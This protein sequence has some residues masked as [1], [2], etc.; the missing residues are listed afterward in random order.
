MSSTNFD[1]CLAT[2]KANDTLWRTGGTDA[3]GN[4]V[5]DVSRI[6]GLTYSMCVS[7]CGSAPIPFDFASFSTQFS[8]FMLPFLALTAQLPFGAPNHFDNFA[9]IMLTIG[10]PT[11]AIFSLMITIFNSRWIQWRFERI[12]YPN[13]NLAVIV[14]DNLQESLLR[15]KQRSFDGRLSLLASQIVLPQNDQ[16]WQ[17]GAATLAFTHT[18]SMSNI[19]SV[20]WAI[21]AYIFTIASMTPSTGMDGIG[22]TVACAWLWLLP[23]VVGWLQMSPNCDEVKLRAKVAALN[24]TAYICRSGDDPAALPV[25]A[26]ELTDEHAIEWFYLLS[27]LTKPIDCD[28]IDESRSPPFY[29]YARMFPWA[30][31]V[32]EIALAF[33]AASIRASKRLTINGSLWTP[34]TPGSPPI[35]PC[36]RLGKA[37][38]AAIYILPDGNPQPRDKC[39]APGVWRRVSYSGIVACTVQ[40][41]CTGS[42][43]LA[44]WMT[45]T[46]GLGC[47]SAALLQHGI[48]STI[49]FTTILAGEIIAQR[50][51]PTNPLSYS[52]SP[53][54][55]KRH[56]KLSALCRRVGKIIAWV[57]AC[58]F[59]A[60]DLISF[61]N[62][63]DNRFCA[64]AV[65]GRGAHTAFNVICMTV[66]CTQRVGGSPLLLS[67]LRPHFCFGSLSLF[68]RPPKKP[69]FTTI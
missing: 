5:D 20:G 53:S 64:S 24:E 15:V 46:I 44:A 41:S 19:A 52:L 21:I 34:S 56:V 38:D 57:N 2:V 66:R 16:W 23:V 1:Q 37:E 22:F 29:N 49:S 18:W 3:T 51:H 42:A 65:M 9:T 26:Y 13:S 27:E 8:S 67:P 28:T 36:N 17:R 25:L 55:H 62:L 40:W 32:E 59:L 61:S 39:W 33:E 6:V 45:P 35:L 60:L 48:L 10:S 69:S 68:S 63:F 58:M 12:A 31:S 47:H 14:L 4:L 54:S 11:L 50:H 7:Q 43:V 30:R